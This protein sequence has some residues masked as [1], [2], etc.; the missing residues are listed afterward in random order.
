MTWIAISAAALMMAHQ[1]AG[2]AVRDSFFLSSYPVSDLPRMVMAAAAASLVL[3]LLFTRAMERLGPRRL[4]PAGFALSAAGH[5]AEFTFAA[6]TP[7]VWAVVIYLHIV[8]FGAI[9]LSGFWSQMSEAFDPRTAKQVFGRIAGGGTLGGIL[10]G[11]AAERV[12]ALASPNTVVLMLAGLHLLCAGALLMARP[13]TGANA[14][15][16]MPEPLP[17]GTLLKRAPYLSTLALLVASGTAAAAIIDYLFKAGASQTVG[18][19]TPLL[20]FF[21]IFYTGTQVL[22]FLAQTTLAQRAL[23]RLGI[24]RTICALPGGV[25]LGSLG[26]ML[27]P[28]FPTFALLRATEFGLRG[29]LFRSGYELLYTPVPP[30]EKR[31]AKTLIDVACDRVGDA[32]GSGV[33]Q[34][35]LLLGGAFLTSGLLATA[36]LISAIGIWAALRLD[37]IYTT[38][39]RER[40]LDRAVE[41]DLDQVEDFTTRSVLMTLPATASHLAPAAAA[42]AAVMRTDAVVDTLVALRSADAGRVL[43]AIQTLDCADPLIAA[44]LIHLLAWD[45]VSSEASAVLLCDPCANAGLLSDQLANPVTP[46]GVRRRIPRLLAHCETRLAVEGLLAGLNDS[47]FEVR[48]QCSRALDALHTRR[49]ELPIDSKCIFATVERELQA[50]R[51]IWESRRLLDQRDSADPAAY[52]DDLVRERANHS[53]EH[54]F[55]LLATVLAREPV[56][57]AFRALHTDD[58]V[59]HGLAAEYLESVLPKN[60]CERLWALVEPGPVSTAARPPEAV[61]DDLLRSQQSL[62]VQLKNRQP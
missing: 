50:A 5:W 57:T 15:T 60:I 54:V 6:Q 16:Q 23:R 41:L 55:S 59:L 61:L 29:S 21:A 49:P 4:V 28:I 20:R 56:K 9:L 52:F 47:R 1:V 33:V 58:A 51:P 7:G 43:T 36:L 46:F 27:I 42:P 11:L 39:V 35:A 44:Q 53:L 32:L 13:V 30:A 37:G 38:L 3:V 45:E 12:A 14:T 10:G 2:K 62:V 22:T 31:A 19:G 34:C 40:M 17:R 8:G 18:T 25:A 48:F 24:G 26:S